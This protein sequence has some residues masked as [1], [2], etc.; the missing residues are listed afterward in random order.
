MITVIGAGLAGL[1]CALDLAD[2]G[3]AV[4]VLDSGAAAGGRCRSYFDT[5]LGCRLDNG[6][7]LLLSGNDAAYA[8]LRRLR[9]DHTMAGPGAPIFPFI[10]L[11]DGTRWV[12]RPS[13]GRA[14]LW[15]FDRARRVPGTR[16]GDYFSLLRWLRPRAGSVVRD[17][18]GGGPLYER[19]IEPLA[20]A[21]LN[22]MPD[23]GDAGL[24]G[25]VMRQTLLRGG[26]ACI[27]AFPEVGL[28]ESLIDP[29]VAALGRLGAA[30]RL[31]CR[32]TAIETDGARAVGLATT[33]GAVVVGPEDGVVL[34]VPAPVARA[35]LPGLTV[36]TAFEAILNVHFRTRAPAGAAGFI[37]VVGG[38]TEWVFVKPEV[39]SVTVSAANRYAEMTQ[40]EAASRCW[41]EVRTVCGLDGPMPP[42]RVL[43]EKRAT[44]AATPEAARQ[45]PGTDGSGLVNVALAGDW[46]D[47]GL[48]ATIEGALRSGHAAAGR[49]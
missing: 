40:E 46:T 22:T 44:F 27:P 48:P 4:T 37:G 33:D 39:V 12:L 13:S 31:G 29:A 34:A 30:V 6:N 24:M 47:T 18:A 28:S 21:A 43:R 2:A 20:I 16:P 25:A 3:R 10:D 15:L 36:P 5:A 14:P 17:L 42:W 9:T 8:W 23:A 7:H 26:Q 32:V 45:R 11:R 19:L 1:A 35:L 49:W 41:D 38:L